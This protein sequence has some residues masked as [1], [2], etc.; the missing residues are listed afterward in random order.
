VSVTVDLAAE[1][2]QTQTGDLSHGWPVVG[3]AAVEGSETEHQLPELERL[4][5]VV[6]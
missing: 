2:V 1:R 5:E 3:A 4:G 6:V